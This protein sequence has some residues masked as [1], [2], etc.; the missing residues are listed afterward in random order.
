MSITQPTSPGWRQSAV[1]VAWSLAWLFVIDAAVNFAFGARAASA[2]PSALSRYFEYGRSVEGKLERMVAADPKAGGQLIGTGWIDPAILGSK[3]AQVEAGHDLL[4]AVYGSSFA[5]NATHE[6]ARLDSRITI[7]DVG[8]PNAPPSHSYAAYKSD[9]PLRKADV[10]VFGVLSSGVPLMGS[11]SGLVWLFESPAPYTFPRYRVS[12]GGE[13]TE[14]LPTIRTEADFRRAFGRQSAEW[15]AFKDQLRRSDRGYD[16]FTL[17][18]SVADS[19]SVVRLVRRGWVAH[20]Q[21]YEE[22]VYDPVSGFNAESEEVRALKAMLVDLKRRTCQRGERLIVLLLH[23]QRQAD[24]LYRALEG[25]LK[26]ANVEYV[27][28]HA[29]FSANDARNFV[30]DGHYTPEAN[31][32]L[33]RALQHLVRN[34][35]SSAGAGAC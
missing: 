26:Q 28:T 27:S 35:P 25:T 3:P 29:L 16:R 6:A 7:R 22:S 31:A 15:I 9:A 19:S 32:E 12:S 4:M 18:A 33:A 2:Q 34:G 8:G 17:D 10:V 20:R 23:T 24:H 5:L 11:M 1:I 30:P 14:E 21:P 13:L